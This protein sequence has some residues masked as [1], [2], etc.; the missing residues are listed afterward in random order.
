MI[1]KKIKKNKVIIPEEV[2][3]LVIE[4]LS[5]MDGNRKIYIGGNDDKDGY[6]YTRDQLIEHIKKDDS[7]GKTI[8]DIEMSF[9]RALGNGSLQNMMENNMVGNNE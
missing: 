7:V 4:R 2:K 8:I 1:K 5:I 9:L 6:T 3:K